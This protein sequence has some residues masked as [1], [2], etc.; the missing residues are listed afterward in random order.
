MGIKGSSTRA[1]N[2]DNVKVPIENVL[3]EIGKGHK[4]AFNILNIG[5]FKLGAAVIGGAKAVIT[6]SVK[7]AKQRKQF[8]KSISEFGLIKHKIGEMAIRTFVGESMVYRSAGLIDNILSGI[9]KSDP[10]ANE[11]ALKG[12]EEYAVECSIIKVYAS[13]ILDYVVDEAVQ[14]FGESI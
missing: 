9:D 13:E 10:K 8:G 2:L 4:I 11:L 1:L 3:G 7:Y 14:I 5:R 12:I 6:E